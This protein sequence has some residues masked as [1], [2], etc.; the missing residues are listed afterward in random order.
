MKSCAQPPR[1]FFLDRL[2]RQPDSARDLA[3]FGI[4]PGSLFS[5]KT[6]HDQ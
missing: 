3:L 1:K 4:R 6:P 2:I 5:E